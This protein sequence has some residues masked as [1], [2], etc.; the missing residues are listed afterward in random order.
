MTMDI[1]EEQGSFQF[2]GRNS[3]V[4]RKMIFTSKMMSNR[5]VKWEEFKEKK[6]DWVK[7]E[8]DE[9]EWRKEGLAQIREGLHGL[10]RVYGKPKTRVSINLSP[11]QRLGL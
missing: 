4:G 2:V 8:E 7:E 9:I 10:R 11:K 3:E 5:R 1:Y 6:E